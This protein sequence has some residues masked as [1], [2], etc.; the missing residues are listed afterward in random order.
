[1]LEVKFLISEL[2]KDINVTE[3]LLQSI[4]GKPVNVAG[5]GL[6][7]EVTKYDLKEGYIYA[8]ISEIMINKLIKED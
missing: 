4:I 7:G 2:F 8:N 1:M 6:V 3:S 5:H